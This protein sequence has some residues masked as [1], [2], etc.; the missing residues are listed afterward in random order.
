MPPAIQMRCVPL[1][2]TQWPPPQGVRLTPLGV[3]L[4][5][6]SSLFAAARQYAEDRLGKHDVA[7]SPKL[8]GLIIIP[9]GALI[10]SFAALEDIAHT[11]MRHI[12]R[13]ALPHKYANELHC[14]EIMLLPY[15]VASMNIEHAYF[16]ATGK[17]E[18]FDG[19]CL[20]DTFQTA[21]S[22]PK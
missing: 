8:F 15:Y 20:V 11:V 1:S 12:P 14:N 13:S 18:A 7:V 3:V 2:P 10:F 4:D 16:E 5:G 19:I 6:V 17:Y 22:R 21:E 9:A